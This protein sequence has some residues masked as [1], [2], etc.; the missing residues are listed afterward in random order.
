[1]GELHTVPTTTKTSLMEQD[2]QG[3]GEYAPS[4]LGRLGHQ[5]THLRFKRIGLKENSGVIA[6]SSAKRAN[7]RAFSV[8]DKFFGLDRAIIIHFPHFRR[9]TKNV[10]EVGA[11]TFPVTVSCVYF[12][13]KPIKYFK[14]L[15]CETYAKSIGNSSINGIA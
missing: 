7:D 8:C 12:G 11:E 2:W 15:N 13:K 4:A 3:P 5:M 14:I 6:R 9:G 10:L 1:M